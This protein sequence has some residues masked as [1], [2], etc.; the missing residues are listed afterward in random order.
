MSPLAAQHRCLCLLLFLC[1]ALAVVPLTHAQL[2]SPT[3]NNPTSSPPALAISS[4]DPAT[5]SGTFLATYIPYWLGSYS[6]VPSQCTP[7][8]TCCC[9]N[10]QPMTVTASTSTQ[11]ASASAA[12]VSL[13]GGSDGG[14]GCF[15]QSTLGGVMQ[16]QS[17][18]VAGVSYPPLGLNVTAQLSSDWQTLT[19]QSS[20]TTCAVLFQ[21]SA[22]TPPPSAATPS[23]SAGGGWSPPSF[24]YTSTASVVPASTSTGVQYQS[25]L[26][27]LVSPAT[28]A[29]SHQ[30]A[31]AFAVPRATPVSSVFFHYA[32]TSSPATQSLSLALQSASPISFGD[33][34]QPLYVFVYSPLLL[35]DADTLTYAFSYVYSAQA[36][37]STFTTFTYNSTLPPAIGTV[38]GGASGGSS[39]LSS[40]QPSLFVGQYQVAAGCVPSSTCCCGVGVVS[41][42]TASNSAALAVT[43]ALDGGTGCFGQTQLSGSFTPSASSPL[44]LSSTFTAQGASDTFLLALTSPQRL[45]LPTASLSSLSPAQLAA[46]ESAYSLLTVTNT[47]QPTCA[48]AAVRLATSTAVVPA[49]SASAVQLPFIGTYTFDGTCQ[50]SAACCCAV[51]N[52]SVS[53]AAALSSLVFSGSLDGSAACFGQSSL[54]ETFLV[55]SPT[56][57]AFS[58][59]PVN[60]TATIVRV[61]GGGGVAGAD[62][63]NGLTFVNNIYPACT[64]TAYRT[65]LSPDT[66]AAATAPSAPPPAVLVPDAALF[67]SYQSD[68]SCVPSPQCCCTDGVTRIH[69]V[70][71]TTGGSGVVVTTTLDGV[72]LSCMNQDG[73]V[74]LNFTLLDARHASGVFQ[75]VLFDAAW[76]GDGSVVISNSL[77][78]SCPTRLVSAASNG[79]V[80]REHGSAGVILLTTWAIVASGLGLLG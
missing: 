78:P 36:Q 20:K 2:Q 3:V 64:S 24:V 1:V 41:I 5:A 35:S 73:P 59:P 13:Q 11:S 18:H 52:L 32:T 60:L 65:S 34:S 53:P 40:T 63:N 8:A 80:H 69:R 47:L 30:Y 19:I 37:F 28:S 57:A 46:V 10:G 48:T 26:L 33:M 29:G 16:L 79:G 27:P 58:L 15:Y 72:L 7:S 17:E 68:G 67:G 31:V 43:G 75:S 25:R 4:S 70:S 12:S 39:A 51:G 74:V 45:P 21:R 44:L 56:T 77:H 66:T 62:G 6:P 55:A 23:T 76:Q 50:S 61:A 49:S 9:S 71:N 54:A 14:S 22:A 38:S 42:A